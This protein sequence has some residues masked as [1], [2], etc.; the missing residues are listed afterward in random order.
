LTF[1]SV[2]S[3]RLKITFSSSVLCCVVPGNVVL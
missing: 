3:Y 1:F 2:Y